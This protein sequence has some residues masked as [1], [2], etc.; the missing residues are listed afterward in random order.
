MIW[1][2][3]AIASGA[4]SLTPPDPDAGLQAWLDSLE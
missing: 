2:D 4:Q 3:A 1:H